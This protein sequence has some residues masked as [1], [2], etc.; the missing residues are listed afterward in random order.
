MKPLKSLVLNY[1]AKSGDKPVRPRALAKKLGVAKRDRQEFE[2]LLRQ[3]AAEGKT[4]LTD[5]GRVGNR[6][7]ESPARSGLLRGIVRITERGGWFAQHPDDDI[8]RDAFTF[9]RTANDLFIYPEHLADAHDG[10]EVLVKPLSQRVSHGRRSGRIEKIL[11]RHTTSFVGT[12]FEEHKRSFVRVDGK[13]FESP[14]DV[15]DPGAKGATP[16]DKVVI[17][18]VRFPSPS[19]GGEAVI[20]RILGARGEPGVD[21]QIIIHELSLPDAFPEE[22]MAAAREQVAKFDETNLGDRTD[23]T[24]EVI[25]TID[26]V[27]AR[28]FD[29]AISLSRTSNGHWHLGVHIADVAHFVPAKS[30]LDIE[31]ARRGTSVYLPGRVLPMIPEQISNGLASLQPGRVRFT[32]SVLIEFNAEGVPLHTEFRNSAIKSARR[33]AYEEIMPIVKHPRRAAETVETEIV[34]LISRMHELA[35]I[36]RS[37]RF[38]GGALE[39]YLPETKLKLD[40]EGKV[41]GV[42]VAE[43]DESHQMIEEFMLA[44]NMAVAQKLTEL[45]INFL[46]RNH[47]RPDLLKLKAFAEFVDSLGFPLRK[48]QSRHELQRLLDRV[49]GQPF[50]Q[51]VN[52]AMLRSMKQAEYSPEPQGHYALAV[53]DY[54]HFTSPIRRYPDLTVH[55]LLD[56]VIRRE[57]GG[58]FQS[59]LNRDPAG[60][61]TSI[62]SG[63]VLQREREVPMSDDDTQSVCE[64]PFGSGIESPVAETNNAESM[65]RRRR[66]LSSSKSSHDPS[67]DRKRRRRES[68]A[69]K[70]DAAESGVSLDTTSSEHRIEHHRGIG[71]GIP[72]LLRLGLHCSM[73]ERRAAQAERAL[74]RMKLLRLFEGF[75]SRTF[76]V[77]IT[78]VEKKGIFARSL[79]YPVDGFIPAFK[80]S[81]GTLDYDRTT[82][83]LI[84]RRGGVFRLGDRLEVR[85]ARLDADE[86]VLEWEPLEFKARDRSAK[87][88]KRREHDRQSEPTE[89]R[90]RKEKTRSVPAKGRRRR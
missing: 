85:I 47:G 27:D 9:E 76:D 54:C 64:A 71:M 31:A 23:L 17:E 19:R 41:A 11:K 66:K 81:A 38:E 12:Y 89:R 36:L 74:I 39:L 69:E 43:H 26:P 87:G 25:I 24:Q 86:R 10:D 68:V 51:A 75:R 35:M 29:D 84:S 33:F 2:D 34:S 60:V 4:R 59:S 67:N 7:Q 32:K 21:E 45:D 88:S 5:D 22:V 13:S 48:Y 72:L 56:A 8:P 18:M 53:E 46:R 90:R 16:G 80:L 77:V 82:R 57:Q 28:D 79:E 58:C 14:I 44:A 20:T 30:A 61:D 1:L 42:K 52:F 73:T 70:A 15:G 63:A 37:R 62:N 3:L 55:R 83:T 40:A 49:K 6:D 78:G 50:E 65:V